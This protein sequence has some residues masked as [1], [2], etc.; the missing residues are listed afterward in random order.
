MIAAMRASLART[1][2]MSA[3]RLRAYQDRRLRALVRWA[4]AR[5]PFYR[6]WFSQAGVDPRRIRGADDLELLPLIDRT[7]LSEAPERFLV[8]PHRLVWESHTSGTSGVPVTVFRSVGS[9]MW[10]LAS[11]Q[12]QWSWFGIPRDARSLELRGSTFAGDDPSVVAHHIPGAHRLLVSSFRLSPAHLPAILDAIERFRPQMVEG[13]PSSLTLLAGL[14]RDAGRTVPVRGVVTSS[15]LMSPAQVALLR[16][17]FRAP[18]VDHY[19]QTE[20]VVMAGACERGSYHL[21]PDYGILELLPDEDGSGQREVVGTPLHNWAFPIFRYRTGDRVEAADERPCPCGRAFPRFGLVGGRTEDLVRTAEGR[22][23]PLAS[24][25]VDDL[26]GLREAQFVQH[27]PGVFEIRMVP[28]AGYDRAAV[29]RRAR[30]NLR[31]MGGPADTLRFTEMDAIPRSGSGKLRLVL[32]L[33]SGGMPDQRE[34][35]SA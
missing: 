15:E 34:S 23:L 14:L 9:S 11:L 29:E 5:S 26:T 6:E 28:G 24:A 1:E 13:W 16:E 22:P 33:D 2:R 30:E 19:G 7:H 21:F 18:V 8:Y 4:A 10:E 31:L 27:R 3:G 20:R 32:V 35:T 17:V 25:I 12:R